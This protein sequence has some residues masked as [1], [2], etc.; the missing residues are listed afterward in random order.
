MHKKM[1][2]WQ[3]KAALLTAGLLFMQCSLAAAAPLALTLE[4]SIEMAIRQNPS[5]QIAQADKEKSAWSVAESKAG[6]LPTISLGSSYSVN[7]KTNDFSTADV[8]NS[9]RLNWQVYSGGRVENQ[10]KQAEIGLKS[11]DLAVE[12]TKQQLKLDT[13]S[14]YFAVLQAENLVSVN[15]ETVN[16]LKEHQKVV[17][18]KYAAGV[19]AKSDVLRAEVELANAEQ[20]L[21]KAQNQYELAVSGLNNI[22]NVAGDTAIDLKDDLKYTA[23]SGTLDEYIAQAK[24]NRPDIAQAV[25]SVKIAET[26]VKIAQGGKQPTVSLAASSG[27]NDSLL[28]RDGNWSVGLSASWNVFD[29]GSTSAKIKQAEAVLAK[30]SL[31]VEQIEDS[32]EQEVRQAFLSL[33]EAEKRLATVNVAVDKA[34]E[35]LFIAREKYAAGVGTNLDVIDAQLALT[36]ARTNHIQALYDYNL[37]KAKLDKAIGLPVQ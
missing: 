13:A 15:Q 30:A 3:H 29:A 16:N 10:I 23:Y 32:V 2:C 14:A 11:A 18:A 33:K 6:R 9:V 12:K 20:N 35:D 37:N 26:G 27:W 24:Q 8:N 25:N 21:I 1:Q 4:D 22:L 34:K 31:Q 7:D 28:P 17:Q 19:V 5:L 36:Q